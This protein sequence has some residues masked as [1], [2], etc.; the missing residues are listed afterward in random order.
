[1]KPSPPKKPRA[2]IFIVDD[3][4][5]AREGLAMLIAR[6][7][8]LT[9]AGL[10]GSAA[11]AL[12]RLRTL[13]ADLLVTDLTLPG[14]SGVEWIK[15]LKEHAPDLPVLVISM[16]DEG[17]YAGRVLKAGASG[18]I[19]KLEG[20]QKIIAAIRRVLAGEV[21]VSESVSARILRSMN[22]VSKKGSASPMER[23]SDRE[24]EVFR[25][26]AQGI[27]TRE[28]ARHLRISAK[29][30]EAHRAN[31]KG[32]LGVATASE[33]IAYGARWMSQEALS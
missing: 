3:E 4:P 2:S 27:S 1:M 19:R 28:I 21:Y 6:E 11:A 13:E 7:P 14:Q 32:K 24:F 26:I 8:D 9:I 10:A 33:L 29:T 16:S 17:F 18:F 5:L 30:V 31:L 25:L 15:I 20:G 22:G 12:E 23:L